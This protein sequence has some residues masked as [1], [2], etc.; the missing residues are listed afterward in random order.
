[1]RIGPSG[2]CMPVSNGIALAGSS[3]DR[4]LLAKLATGQLCPRGTRTAIPE[5]NNRRNAS[6]ISGVFILVCWAFA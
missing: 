4:K 1:M 5:M 6:H 3:K 2:F